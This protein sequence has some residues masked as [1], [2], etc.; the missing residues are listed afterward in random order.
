MSEQTTARIIPTADE[1]A[2]MV[3]ISAAQ[4]GSH[5]FWSDY[6]ELFALMAA[7]LYRARGEPNG[8]TFPQWMQGVADARGGSSLH[9]LAMR[10]LDGDTLTNV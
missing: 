1:L 7:F 10:Y 5:W 2:Q 8:K 9:D 4:A 3:E 6:F